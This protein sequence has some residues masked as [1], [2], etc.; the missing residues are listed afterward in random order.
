MLKKENPT[1]VLLGCCQSSGYSPPLPSPCVG[2]WESVIP[3]SLKK[4]RKKQGNKQTKNKEM[5][6]HWCTLLRGPRLPCWEE[7]GGS[8]LVIQ[9]DLD[10][11]GHICLFGVMQGEKRMLLQQKD[12]HKN[13]IYTS[14]LCWINWLNEDCCGQKSK[15]I[16]AG[17]VRVEKVDYYITLKNLLTINSV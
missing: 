2:A 14:E 6:G 1:P 7:P 13:V 16:I 11:T 3:V 5:V 12:N 15:H 9:N 4:D 17:M 8:S 10:K